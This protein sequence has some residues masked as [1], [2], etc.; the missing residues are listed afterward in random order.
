MSEKDIIQIILDFKEW[1]IFECKRARIDPSKVLETIVAFAN[2]EGGTLVLGLED[3]DK[4]LR[5]KRLVGISENLDNVSDII[6]LIP[7]EISPALPKV[8]ELR[9][10]IINIHGN[11]DELFVLSIERS[12]DVHSLRRGDTYLRRG[13][14]NNKLTAQEIMRLKY[15]KGAIRYESEPALNVDISDLD[16][17]IL[18]KFQQATGSKGPN[19]IQFL[20]DNG[21]TYRDNGKEVLNRAAVLLFAENPS[22]ALRS[23]CGIKISH[24]FGIKPDYSGEPNF[25]RKPFT[26][27]GPLL[28]QIQDAYK[29]LETGLINPPKLKGT[30]FK[31]SLKY[32]NWVLQEAITN[33]V[34]HRDYSIQNDIQIRIFDNRI[35]F[36]SPGIFPGHV[37]VANIRRERFARNPI[38]LRTLNRFGEESPN[39][40]IGEGVDRMCKMMKKANL[41]EPIYFPPHITPNSVLLFLFNIERITYWD[42]VSKYL[43]KKFKITNK[44]LRQITG[45]T[46]TLKASRLLRTWTKQGLLEEGRG[47]SKKMKYYHKAGVKLEPSLFS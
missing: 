15:A 27:E 26:I 40:D 29:Y 22:V 37:T 2:A 17:I 28:K 3:P 34:I 44:E 31:S 47:T 7:K 20:K 46:D 11:K 8:K 14:H 16:N 9:I 23:K 25:V 6:N 19:V 24:Y 42:T 39:L 10:P 5:E 41:Y 13:R 33:A 43:D 21:L 45:I 18:K 1:Q 12:T 35:E 30:A 4:A 36:E 32:P 38:I